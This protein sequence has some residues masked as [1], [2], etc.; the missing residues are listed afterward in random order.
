M[1]KWSSMVI[2]T[3]LYLRVSTQE[4]QRTGLEG[5]LIALENYY[6]TNG[7]NN[8]KIYLD[9]G[10]SGAKCTRP[11]LGM[12]IS[13]CKSGIVSQVIVF[14]FSRFGRSLKH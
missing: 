7:I 11:A 6:K 10:Y 8:Y 3:A 4:K 1:A 2:Y 14:S 12:L 9:V 5:Q 13:D